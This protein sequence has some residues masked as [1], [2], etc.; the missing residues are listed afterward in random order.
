MKIGFIGLG[1]MGAGIAA[2]ILRGGHEVVAWNRSP[3]PLAALVAQGAI[4]APTAQ[5]TLE[6]DIVFSMLA[7][8]GALQDVGLD[9]P[10]LAKASRGLV[11]VNMA[12]VS[13]AFARTLQ[14]THKAFGIGYVAAPVFG[15]PDAA[16]AGKLTVIAAG[17]PADIARV[18]PILVMLGAKYA[19]VGPDPVQANLFKITGNF[20]IAAAI[21]SMGEAAALLRKGGVDP[22]LFF[23]VMTNA[24]FSAPVYKIYGKI[25]ADQAYDKAG[26]K[27]SLG[28]KDAG[29]TLA[30][31]KE[32]EAPM[33]LASMVHD[34]FIEAMAVGWSEKDWAAL[35][36]LAAERAG[37]K[38]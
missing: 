6:T 16:A 2:N 3:G 10:L 15:R 7:N 38:D 34:H 33:P 13:I 32:L 4:A 31:A 26:F 28:Y 17:A 22:V 18:E 24:N 1:G 20:M 37:L 12:T 35:A 36:R 9:G 30:A 11:H 5:E 14:K 25:I 8:D 29:L 23:D 27:L 19:C 21:E